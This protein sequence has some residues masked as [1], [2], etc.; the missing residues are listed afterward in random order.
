MTV[1]LYNGR[2]IY[3][4][5]ETYKGIRWEC[6]GT[7]KVSKAAAKES[8]KRARDNRRRQIDGE[9]NRKDGNVPLDRELEKWYDLYKARDGRTERT[10]VTDTDTIR[11]IQGSWLGRTKLSEISSDDI[12]R[13]L[14]QEAA[15]QMGSALRR[16]WLMLRMYY[17]HRSG[18][19]SPMER[20]TLPAPGK[21]RQ[22]KAAYTDQ[23]IE[24]LTGHFLAPIIP[25]VSGMIYGPAL[26]VCL[27]AFL[28]HGEL[29]GLHVGDVDLE[30][31]II[32]IRR[33]WQEKVCAEVPPKYG[34]KRDVP[35]SGK[36]RGIF[37]TRL[38]RSYDSVCREG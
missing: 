34:S 22:E 36:I 4:T 19:E 27:Y 1:Y 37:L 9:A 11:Q 32:H 33:Q 26:A 24:R 5:I 29:A 25:G 2:F 35:I 31:G 17:K 7:S 3:K 12:Q 10:V 15:G 28:R 13:Y 20:C 30:R 6:R 8:W 38:R 23:E 14:N 21:K 18:A 16:K